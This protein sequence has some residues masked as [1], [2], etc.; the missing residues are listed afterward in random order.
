MPVSQTTSRRRGAPLEIP[1]ELAG[2]PGP[3]A[4][5]L[6]A[7]LRDA[8][9]AGRLAA[10]LRLPS[11][12]DLAAQ[13]GL[14]RNAVVAAYEALVGEGLLAADLGAGTFVAARLPRPPA[15]PAAT[16][17]QAPPNH[18]ACALGVTAAAPDLMA[19]L[20][21][22][23]RR[24]TL[25]A[26]AADLAYGDPR[27]SEA[28]R[29]EIALH[30]AASRGI[31]CDPSCI[32]IVGGI[33]QG[34]RLCAEALMAPGDPVWFE[35]PGYPA[36]WR[37]LTAAGLRPVPVPVDGEGID[38]AEGRRRAPAARAAYVT[39]SNQFPTGVTLAMERRLA[40]LDWARAQKAW[41]LEDD[42]DNEFRYD[43]LPLTA[44]AGI[45]GDRVIYC[46]TFSKSLFAG[47]RLA[48]CVV[49]PAAMGRVV[50]TREAH[51]RFPP[52]LLEAALAELM[53]DGT[54]ARHTRRMRSRYR[55]GRDV[56]AQ[57]LGEAA[58]DR[59]ALVVP[60]QGLHLLAHL[61][62]GTPPGAA[63]RILALSGIGARLLGE[64]RHGAP[65]PEGFVLG[66]AGHA[67][68]DLAAAARALGAAI[69]TVLDGD[70]PRLDTAAHP[71]YLSP[72]G[73]AGPQDSDGCDPPCGPN[74]WLSSSRSSSP[75]D[76]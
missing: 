3:Q 14:G 40:L 37:A 45:G 56:L 63:A 24:R 42:Y 5:R 19:R 17:A 73:P 33:Q 32:L 57:A 44:L 35:D 47:L 21:A 62:P 28:L 34:L 51:D 27:G 41:V 10:G 55:A 50:A 66:F 18:R 54:L 7:G 67:P 70:A 2:R 9:L 15:P 64:M 75:W 38:V 8:I 74:P 58:G 39:P 31:R 60:R 11:S 22:A 20:A 52:V 72:S 61:P 48:Y 36:A 59:L 25:A 29:R 68:R 76:C 26:G 4:L 13:L 46:G 23:L 43:G 49:P 71:L 69:R 1:L 12:R 6:Q 65:G 53:A 30:L 16:D